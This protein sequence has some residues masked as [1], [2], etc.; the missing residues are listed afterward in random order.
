[1]DKLADKLSEETGLSYSGAT[2]GYWEREQAQIDKE[3]RLVL[4]GFLSI[5]TKEGVVK[6]LDEANQF[7][8]AGNF[9]AL[10]EDEIR[11]VNP[12]WKQEVPLHAEEQRPDNSPAEIPQGKPRIF[13]FMSPPLPPQGIVGRKKI[14]SDLLERL[15]SESAEQRSNAL[16]LLGFGG[17]GKTSIAISIAHQPA[18]RRQFPDGVFWAALGPQPQTRYLLEK[19]GKEVGLELILERSERECSQMLRSTFH[20][21]QALLIVDD[22]WDIK[23]GQYFFLAGPGSRLV[24]TT[25][26]TEPANSLTAKENQFRVDFLDDKSSLSLLERLAPEVVHNEKKDAMELCRRLGNLPLAITLAG[27]L[28]AVESD[29]PGKMKRILS[30]LIDHHDARLDLIQHEGRLGLD[31]DNPVSLQAIL[32]LSVDRLKKVDKER[33][34]MLAVFGGEPLSWEL[35]EAQYIWDCS[36]EEAEDSLQELIKRGLVEPRNGEYGMHALLADYAEELR[37]L[38]NL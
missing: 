15:V 17:I 1:M 8:E 27:R 37:I 33:F 6:T 12:N 11:E 13:T 5:F 20:D 16:G 35:S 23:N 2:I 36:I 25:R 14:I 29:V 9:R 32:G 28:L 22:I 18:I 4:Q 19:W 34:S 30:E 31:E 7:L 24:F 38:L 21:L 10:S 3:N 26:E